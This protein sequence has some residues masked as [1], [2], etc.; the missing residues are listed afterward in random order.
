ML[1]G[2]IEDYNRVLHM[3]EGRITRDLIWVSPKGK[4]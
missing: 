2:E 4:K 1:T 3:K